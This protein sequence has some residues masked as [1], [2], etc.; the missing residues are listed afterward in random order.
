MIYLDY[1]ATAPIK[2]EVIEEMAKVMKMGGNPSSVHSVGRQAK[3][4]LEKSRHSIGRMIN[5]HPQKIIFTSGGTEANNIALKATG[6]KHLIISAAEH[7]SVVQTTRDFTGTIDILSVDQ[8]GFISPDELKEYLTKAPQNTLVSIM[9]ANNETGVIQDIKTL[10]AI[11]HDFGVL[12]H[13]DAIQ[14]FGKIPIDFRDLGVDM[15][16]LSGHKVGGPQGI[17]ALVALEKINISPLISG[18]G[19]EVG[20]RSGTENLA[21]I[22]GFAKAVSLMPQNLQKMNDIQ[23]LRDGLEKS[24]KSHAPEV[25]FF[26]SQSKRLPNTSAIVMP[27]VLSETQVMAFDLEGI[28]VSSGSA[29]SS[30]KVKPSHVVKAMG[31]TEQQAMSVIR[32]SLGEK[33]SRDDVED[34][35]SAWIRL[36]ERK[37]KRDGV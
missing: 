9:M 19:Q 22:A 11:A 20:R 36:Y 29:C 33:T 13:T 3:S 34:F 31:G 25:T 10:A 15:M 6:A 2:P 4:V 23:A 7:D 5:C 28:C 8:N 18:G 35:V 1:N 12:F 16:S 32:V 24:I 17:G 30:G 26:G 37:R 14:A 21:G 27:D